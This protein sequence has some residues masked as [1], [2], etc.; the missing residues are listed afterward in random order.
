MATLIHA[1]NGH[2]PESLIERLK[3]PVAFQGARYE[4][5]VAALFAHLDCEIEFLDE[6]EELKDK[7]RPEFVARHRPTGQDVA[8]EAKSRHR[9]GVLSQAGDRNEEEPLRGDPRAVRALFSKA[10]RKDAGGRPLLIFIDM[11]APV[12]SEAQGLEKAWAKDIQA[13][14]G[15]MEKGLP[16]T[17]RSMRVFT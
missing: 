3:D 5:A 10:L 15:R 6:V 11:N 14:M 9:P 13:W 2:L 16:R 7:P 12:E 4:L 17:R 8:V 1:T